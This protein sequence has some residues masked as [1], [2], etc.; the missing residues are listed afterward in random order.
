MRCIMRNGASFIFDAEDEVVARSHTWSI[1]RGYARTIINGRTVFF[2]KLIM[3]GSEGMEIDHISMDRLD[4]RRCN[5]RMATH[6]QNQQNR[7]AHK[8]NKSGYKGVC[9]DR[10]TEKYFAYINADGRRTYLG[11]YETA[12]EAALAYDNA[13]LELHKEFA[14]PNFKEEKRNEEIL[15]LDRHSA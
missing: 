9:L 12:S 7:Q 11:S 6:S 2:H 4:N 3:N 13:C 10:R 1:S 5:L 14:R 15:E 8:D